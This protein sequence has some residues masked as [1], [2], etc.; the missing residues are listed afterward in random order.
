MKSL[1]LKAGIMAGLMLMLSV[2]GNAQLSQQ[3]RAQV[4]FDFQAKGVSYSA[5][6]YSLGPMSTNSSSGAVA[7]RNRKSGKMRV[8][9]QTQLGGDARAETG[10]LIFVKANGIYTLSQIV[11]PTFELKMKAT[12]TD[13]RIAKNRPEKRET[14]AVDLRH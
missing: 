13:V 3:Y 2:A 9:G 5:G 8:I 11:T 12:S 4:P 6:E 7:I 1:L 14:V 10:K